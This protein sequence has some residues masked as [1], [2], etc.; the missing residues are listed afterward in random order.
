MSRATR[1]NDPLYQA[2]VGYADA[3]SEDDAAYERARQRLIAEV[4][5]VLLE[6]LARRAEREAK[7]K[8]KP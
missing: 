8:G 7:L 1:I 6:K 3:D 2:M 5:R 4:E